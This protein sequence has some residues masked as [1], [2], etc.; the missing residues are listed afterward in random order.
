[1]LTLTVTLMVTLTVT[2]SPV[3]SPHIAL[4]ARVVLRQSFRHRLEARLHLAGKEDDV[5]DGRLG[6]DSLCAGEMPKIR[7]LEVVLRARPG[8]RVRHLSRH[9]KEWDLIIRIC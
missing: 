4:I 3:M 8:R 6:L 5:R 1:M 9:I 2:L 7:E